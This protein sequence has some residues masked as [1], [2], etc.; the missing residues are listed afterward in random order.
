MVMAKL[1][2]DGNVGILYIRTHFG[3]EH[4]IRCEKADNEIFR[5]S[6][7]A[8]DMVVCHEGVLLKEDGSFRAFPTP[9]APFE[10]VGV[11]SPEGWEN[12]ADRHCY[13]TEYYPLDM[14]GKKP[15][16]LVSRHPIKDSNHLFVNVDVLDGGGNLVK[17]YR[18]SPFFG[19]HKVMS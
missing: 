19:T 11:L 10:G 4:E 18:V 15:E 14:E 2:H 5:L 9:D 12:P 6:G 3:T 8:A 16:W 13:V 17:R 7:T 1:E